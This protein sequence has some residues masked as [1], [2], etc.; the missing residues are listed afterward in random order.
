MSTKFVMPPNHLILCRPLLP[1]PSIFPSIRVCSSESSLLIKWPKCWSFHVSISPSSEYSGLIPFRIDWGGFWL[2]PAMKIR[3]SLTAKFPKR[4]CLMVLTLCFCSGLF[5]I[6]LG[7]I[8]SHLEPEL[9]WEGGS[10]W[11]THVNPWLIYVSV[12]QKPLQYCKLISLQLLK[13]NGKK[14]V[15]SVHDYWENHSLDY[16]D[17]CRQS[18]VSAF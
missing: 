5:S 17:F 11:G 8:N 10:G 4:Q 6:A 2:S 12:C 3:P 15:T 9:W 1:P 14:N 7:T 13:I 18:D 16:M